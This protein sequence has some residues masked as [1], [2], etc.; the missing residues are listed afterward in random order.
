MWQNLGR[1]IRWNRI[2]GGEKQSER[3]A[4]DLPETEAKNFTQ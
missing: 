4:V 1:W 3:D 2:L